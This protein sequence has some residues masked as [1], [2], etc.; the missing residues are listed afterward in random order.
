M[1][2]QRR[3]LLL[4]DVPEA[5]DALASSRDGTAIAGQ[6]VSAAALQQ[7]LERRKEEEGGNRLQVRS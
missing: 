6:Y 2:P 4:L 5:F 3:P 1:S 7:E